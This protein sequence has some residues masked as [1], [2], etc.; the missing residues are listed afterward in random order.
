MT[1]SRQIAL[2]PSAP[3]VQ[4]M[5]VACGLAVA[6]IYY[7]QPLLDLLTR[8]FGIT[9]STASLIVTVTQIGYAAGL[10]FIVPLGDQLDRRRLIAWVAAGTG[11]ASVSA[12][13]SP[14]IA[15]FVASSFFI[16]LTATSAQIMVPM[17][18]H[19]AAEA[20]RGAVVGR[21]MSGLLIGILLARAFSGIVAD[22]AGWRAVFGI[23]AVLMFGLAVV[24][25]RALPAE[26]APASRPSYGATLV[27]VA[28]LL[29]EEP[30]LRRRIVYGGCGFAGFTIVWTALPFLLANAPYHYSETLIGLFSLLGAAGALGANA[31]GRLHD[32]GLGQRAVAGFMLAAILSFVGMG[33]FSTHLVAIMLG[34][35]FMD[36]GVQG[37]QI[38]NQSTIY[39]LRPDARSRIT[40]AYMSCFFVAGALGSALA[41]VSYQLGGWPGTMAVAGV[42]ETTA[43]VFW[44]TE[45][46]P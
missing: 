39:A 12:M 15:W 35:F 19:L 7:A 36:L 13:I 2:T 44:M 23:A 18:A 10:V 40:T 21:V 31:A 38:L 37:V 20:K 43:L 14:G 17:A 27:S 25:Y 45:R 33:L 6:N 9:S 22:A 11:A 34:L 41:G 30:I 8:S 1:H 5:A 4:L 42:L 46:S 16:G 29:A 28:R 24:L 3:L 26:A 32:S